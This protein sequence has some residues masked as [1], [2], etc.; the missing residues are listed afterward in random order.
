ARCRFAACRTGRGRRGRRR[1]ALAICEKGAEPGHQD[2]ARRPA[3]LA[4]AGIVLVA[5]LG[6]FL[7]NR[8]R[9]A[10]PA[11][12]AATGA[13]R[14]EAAPR[15]VLVRLSSGTPLWI[16]LSDAPRRFEP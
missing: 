6:A 10:P 3:W 9:P 11:P 15:T 12:P 14:R 2:D 5:G 4:A 1:R 7:A 16:T 8:Q 13:A